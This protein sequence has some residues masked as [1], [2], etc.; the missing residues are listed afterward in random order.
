MFDVNIGVGQGS[1]L[2]PIL[3]SL[4]L[5]PF[6]YILEKHLKNLKIP[7]SILFFVD[8]GL[9]IA[10]NK[11][12]DISNSQLYCSYNVLS[13][14]LNSF[15]L[16]IK[17][18]KTE[19]F[20]FSRSR[21]FFNPP[22]LNLSL[23]GGP[24]L[25]PKDSW[26]YLGFILDHKLNFH[27]HIDHYTNKALSTIK[28]MKLLGNSS[29]SI[30]P[31][32][33]CLLY[34]CC[35]LH[36]AFY[37]FQLWFY[38]KALLLYHM[39]I[40]NKMQR[41]VAIWILGAFRT[42]PTE[43]VEAIA[44]IIPIRFHLQKI[45]R[46]LQICL[47]KL[48]TNHILRSLMDDSPPSSI[49]SNLHSIG[50]LTDCQKNITKGHLIDSCNKS[51]SIF[52]SFSPL[53]QEFVPGSCIINIFSDYLSFNL[54]TKKD[55]E[56]N[57]IHTHELDIMVLHN[58][59]LPHTALVITDASI[60]NDIAASISH[61]HIANCL[62]TKIVHLVSFV[63]SMEAELF[64]IRCGINQAYSNE[65]VSK[66]I[67]VMDS[68]YAARKIFDSS[69]HPFQCHS[70]AI[71]SELRYFFT[72]NPNNSI[73]FWECPSHLKWRFH[74]NVDKNSKSFNPLPTYPCKIFWDFCK[75]TD[76]DDIINQWKMT[77]QASDGKG[78]HF[79]DLLDDNFN[80]IEPSYM[81]GGFWLQAFGH[82]NSLCAHAMRAITNHA[83]IEKY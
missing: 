72:L 17:H 79:L 15:G 40:L 74:H 63:T 61:I 54:A 18:S 77:F 37:S 60:K 44:G 9:I 65:V 45:A 82:S 25:R 71:L 33:K 35:I 68:I 3:S 69:S 30:S 24:T 39:K 29:H 73:E 22:P 64:A 56:K 57:K 14:L 50:T 21:G 26:K 46:R 49:F 42:S 51:Y 19:I 28:C 23:L 58:S 12:F 66:I 53:N 27:K 43:S 70:S 38:N 62:L 55:K 1:A 20:H 36:I 80:I 52:P 8:D 47:F 83:L 13:K 16:V 59:L 10:Q 5:T 6:L 11:S 75:K 7:I 67:V 2:S 76:S 32:Q 4:Y 31:L 41:R 34:R 48:L 81:K 78:N